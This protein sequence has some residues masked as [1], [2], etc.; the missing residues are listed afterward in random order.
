[1]PIQFATDMILNWNI[2]KNMLQ[3]NS[4]YNTVKIISRN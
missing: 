1:M 2:D 3:E 4:L